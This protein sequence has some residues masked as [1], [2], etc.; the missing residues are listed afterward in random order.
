L[1]AEI[2][3]RFGIDVELVQGARG[4]FEVTLDGKLI[5]SKTAENR[6]PD[7]DEIFTHLS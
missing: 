1:G 2:K 4:A 3:D 7:P 5:F 6:F